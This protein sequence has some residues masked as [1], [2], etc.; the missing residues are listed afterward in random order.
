MASGLQ[1]EDHGAWQHG[2]R[3]PLH[4]LVQ[5]WEDGS[6]F[7]AIAVEDQRSG[8]PPS[9][10]VVDTAGDRLAI[11]STKETCGGWGRHVCKGWRNNSLD[12]SDFQSCIL[13]IA[14]SLWVCLHCS[15]ISLSFSGPG[16][17][18]WMASPSQKPTPRLPGTGRGTLPPLGSIRGDW[19]ICFPP[20]FRLII[21]PK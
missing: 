17:I 5:L 20:W 4:W 1:E 2:G 14:T 6:H 3:R 18:I 11:F 10:V 19:G 16:R 7:R 8:L 12:A 21:H 13:H 9:G 15:C